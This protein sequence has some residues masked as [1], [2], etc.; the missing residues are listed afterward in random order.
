MRVPSGADV[1]PWTI[2]TSLMI[3]TTLLVAGIDDVRVVAG[4]VG[5]D[6]ADHGGT[7]AAEPPASARQRAWARGTNVKR[8]VIETL[9]SSCRIIARWWWRLRTQAASVCHS[10]SSC[11]VPV[12]AAAVERIAPGGARQ[13][14]HQQPAGGRVARYDELRGGLEVLA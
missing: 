6:D 9:Q 4:G 14:M 12:L 13:R 7:S 2:S 5:L 1:T 11:D 8:R 3:P 10:A